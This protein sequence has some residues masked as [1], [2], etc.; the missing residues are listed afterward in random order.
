MNEFIDFDDIMDEC[1]DLAPGLPKMAGLKKAIELADQEKEVYWGLL[2]RELYI[3]EAFFRDD[4]IK[5]FLIFPEYIAL[6]DAHPEVWEEDY[7]AYDMLWVYKWIVGTLDQFYQISYDQA[8]EYM[9]DFKRRCLENGF[10]LRTYYAMLA[11]FWEDIDVEKAKE[12][13]KE[14]SKYQRDDLSDCK[15]CELNNAVIF[16][17]FYGDFEKGMQMAEPILSGQLKCGDIPCATY[18]SI[19]EGCVTHGDWEEV[20]KFAGLLEKEL[21]KKP[22]H[23]WDAGKLLEYLA[24]RDI[25]KGLRIFKKYIQVALTMK[26]PKD[27]YVFFL[28]AYVLFLSIKMQ[29]KKATIKMILPREF[30]LFQENGVYEIDTLI[31]YWKERATTV[32]QKLDTRNGNS[33]YMNEIK[34]KVERLCHSLSQKEDDTLK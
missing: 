33:K 11:T 20:E 6:Y 8:M 2:F 13:W 28:G 4:S 19:L 30:P 3:R 17:L 26:T 10:S 14:F 9:A 15:A 12:M 31:E 32:A 24:Y 25:N 34:D 29:R 16:E 5:A 1:E 7:T 23:I 27:I 18:A 21:R 22:S